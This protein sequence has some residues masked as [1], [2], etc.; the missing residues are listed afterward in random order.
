MPDTI[1]DNPVLGELEKHSPVSRAHPIFRKVITQTL[2]ISSEVILKPA[3]TFHDSD[4]VDLRQCS[5]IL[6]RLW[7]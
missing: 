4:A 2:Y 7:L 1:D 6:F 5:Q 3:Q